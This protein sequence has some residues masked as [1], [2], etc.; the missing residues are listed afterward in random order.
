MRNFY[1]IFL[2]LVW[3]NNVFA[4]NLTL[5]VAYVEF[6]RQ[7]EEE[8]IPSKDYWSLKTDGNKS[9][10]V[11]I[12]DSVLPPGF[13]FV[14]GRYE[15]WKNMN[16]DGELVFKGKITDCNYYYSESI[17]KFN[18]EMLP[19]DS[20]ICG[21][22]CQKAQTTFRGRT[23]IVWYS[24]DIPY[25]DGPWKLCGLPGLILKAEDS[26]KDFSFTAYKISHVEQKKWEINTRMCKK[27]SASDF[28]KRRTI[29]YK[30]LMTSGLVEHPDGSITMRSEDV[31]PDPKTACLVEYFDDRKK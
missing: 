3:C 11:W 21:N 29:A 26:K 17:P 4:T 14:E 18:W 30:E 22:A 10:F 6:Y 5:E 8:V 15:V 9:C 16:K 25:D 1:V 27:S 24:L 23:W 31:R 28:A 7:A 12:P 19:G 20:V 13:S 2:L